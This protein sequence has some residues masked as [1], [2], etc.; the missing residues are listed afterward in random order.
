MAGSKR[1]DDNEKSYDHVLKYTGIFG[2]VQ[3]LT[4]LMGVV[5][6]KLVALLI[7]PSG[8]GF[9]N[10]YNSVASLMHQSTNLGL[11]FS[12]VKHISELSDNADYEAVSAYVK[13]VRTWSVLTALFGMLLCCLLSSQISY[14][15]FGGNDYTG[16]ICMMSPV[17]A[18]MAIVA[19]EMAVM[20]GLKQLK[21]VAVT[22][23]FGAFA[24]L[25][26]CIPVYSLWGI[27]G[28]VPS[29]VLC[30]AAVMFV[31]MYFSCQVVPW[32]VDFHSLS[33]LASGI[34]M[35]RLGLGYIIAGVF[36]QGAE[37]I[38][39][40]MIQESSDI[41]YVGLYNSGYILTVSYASM[42]FVAIEAD[43][44]P[45]LSAACKDMARANRIINQQIEICVLLI[46]PVLI[47]F[48]ISMPYLVQILYSSQFSQAI[49]MSIGATMFMFFRAMTLPA[50][51]LALAK[52]DSKMFMA[53]ELVY[54]IF[55]AIAVPFA[56]RNYGLVGAG[57]AISL[58]GF[59]YFLLIH[60]LYHFKYKY[61]FSLRLF[62]VYISQFVLL[63]SAVVVFLYAKDGIADFFGV[64][65]SVVKW[66]VGIS[67]FVLSSI[68]S[69]RVLRRETNFVDG[70][71]SRIYNKFRRQ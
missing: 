40:T 9:I 62:S 66:G 14:W 13:T 16:E 51:Y 70:F 7:G 11:G 68:V 29:L 47:G 30:N 46:S 37:Y 58:G 65:V 27:E 28:V 6:N 20:K 17:V 5:R 24:T 23:A 12:A 10:M 15:S 48:V 57:W 32:K 61:N 56:F 44:F 8:L 50:A 25:L 33:V 35:V 19:G 63:A 67:L 49:P 34:P 64:G 53:T 55:I 43:F 60:V 41:S 26:V 3:G 2:G 21:K 4:L 69:L 54:D 52:G 71:K 18:F 22:S 39:R 1:I 31:T 59:I 45:R 38:I 42:V 36:G